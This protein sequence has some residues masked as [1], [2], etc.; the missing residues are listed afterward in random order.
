[1][2]IFFYKGL[3]GLIL[4]GLLAFAGCEEGMSSGSD[5]SDGSDGDFSFSE[6]YSDIKSLKEEIAKLKSVIAAQES[7]IAGLQSSQATTVAGLQT[8]F[9]EFAAIF[10]GVSRSENDIVFSGVNVHVVNG[11]GTTD[12]EVNGLGNLIVGYNELRDYQ[13]DRSG[14]HNIVAGWGLSYSSYG[15]LV[16]GRHNTISGAY[17]SVSAGSNNTASGYCS[18]VS[19]GTTGKASGSCSSISGGETGQ[20]SGESSSI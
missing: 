12:G 9:N 2:K 7:V 5:S 19:G 4:A 11:S 15:G 3:L 20:A 17:S 8:D 18:S 16:V 13:D 10:Q 6:I 14:S 1:M